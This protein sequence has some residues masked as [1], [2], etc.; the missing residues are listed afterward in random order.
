VVMIRVELE[1]SRKL[2]AETAI[3]YANFRPFLGDM[4]GVQSVNGRWIQ[5]RRD[6]RDFRFVLRHTK[7]TTDGRYTER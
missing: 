7:R 4:T 5:C 6:Y 1:I 3:N 2:T